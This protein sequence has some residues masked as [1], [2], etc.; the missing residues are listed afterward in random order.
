MMS[1][2]LKRTR[3]NARSSRK[4]PRSILGHALLL[5]TC[6]S[7]LAFPAVAATTQ[8]VQVNPALAGIA[9]SPTMATLAA[10]AGSPP[11]GGP[12]TAK[13]SITSVPADL[14]VAV[15][16][17]Y[18]AIKGEAWQTVPCASQTQTSKLPRPVIGGSTYG[19]KGL[20]V[21]TENILTEGYTTAW[22]SAFS[23]EKDSSFGTDAFSIQA[24]TNAFNGYNGQTDW[25]QFTDQAS[26]GSSNDCVWNIDLQTQTY[27]PVCVS[28]GAQTLSSTFGADVVGTVTDRLVCTSGPII[29]L[30]LFY[31]YLTS[32]YMTPTGTWAVTAP[33][34][35]GL[36]SQW[37]QI[38]GTILGLGD[39]SE[40]IFTHPTKV[41]SNVGAYSSGLTSATT[42]NTLQSGYWTDESNNL[43]Y[44]STSS[45][46]YG[47]GYCVLW[48]Q[49]GV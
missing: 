24:N 33:D 2:H 45:A 25:V 4:M 39:G 38:S 36:H 47:D 3:D 7:L 5:L 23:G 37:T 21:G 41:A 28:T 26:P 12:P 8:A 16:C 19:I 35:Y 18:H 13:S 20:S 22:F 1:R 46:C 48:T 17:Y 15:G 49:M 29:H 34:T 14:P 32:T 40:A 44:Q 27:A 10:T 43:N 11:N 9:M 42:F 30:C 6:A 31:Y